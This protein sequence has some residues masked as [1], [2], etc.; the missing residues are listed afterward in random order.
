[1]YLYLYSE[2]NNNE[3]TEYVGIY[4]KPEP[5]A[6]QKA[7]ESLKQDIEKQRSTVSLPLS[8]LLLFTH[9]TLVYIFIHL[10]V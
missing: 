1:M 2:S 4:S 6:D 3:S 5:K 10:Y 9:N 7:I 8:S